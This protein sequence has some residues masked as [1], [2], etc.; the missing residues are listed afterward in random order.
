MIYLIELDFVVESSL[1]IEYLGMITCLKL[2]P[3][4]K[5]SADKCLSSVDESCSAG[6]VVKSVNL[7]QVLVQRVG[8]FHSSITWPHVYCWFWDNRLSRKRQ[9]Q[10][11][12]GNVIVKKALDIVRSELSYA[13]WLISY[14][15]TT[16]ILKIHSALLGYIHFPIA[17][18][19][20]AEDQIYPI[21]LR[22]PTL[23]SLTKHLGCKHALFANPSGADCLTP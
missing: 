6:F 3:T 19:N 21:P 20:S 12:V 2:S 18:P 23:A 22:L 5:L 7:F 16:S 4:R 1:S 14:N 10:L 13:L 8:R 15:L 17:G 11:Y 9:N